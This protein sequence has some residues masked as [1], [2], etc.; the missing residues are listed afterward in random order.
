MIPT[1]NI[2]VDGDT[3]LFVDPN[4]FVTLDRLNRPNAH[5]LDRKCD[6]CGGTLKVR[7]LP[8]EDNCPDC[9]G[10]GRH[11]F[12]IKVDH[13]PYDGYFDTLRVHVIDVLPITDVVTH[14][15]TTFIEYTS[16]PERGYWFLWERDAATGHWSTK[17]IMHLPSAVEPGMWLIR[18]EIHS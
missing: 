4:G 6:T 3:A 9:D 15:M 16:D 1:S 12:D 13:T 8:Y 2:T 18:L 10:T 7:G 5:V 11:T 14:D 17:P